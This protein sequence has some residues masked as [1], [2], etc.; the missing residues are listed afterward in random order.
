VC[1]D[2]ILSQCLQKCSWNRPQRGSSVL[3]VCDR[4]CFAPLWN[5][6]WWQKYQMRIKLKS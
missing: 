4:W 5:D 2:L 3:L 1:D 6:K